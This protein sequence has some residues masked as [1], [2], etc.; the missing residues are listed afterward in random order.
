M[1]TLAA[2]PLA[3][4]SGTLMP[5]IGLGTW[6][7]VGDEARDT[8]RYALSVGYRLID[9]SEQYGNEEPVGRAIRE[10]GVPREEV[11]L[12]TKFNARWHGFELVQ[13]ACDEALKR[14]G[15]DYVDLFLIHWPNPWEDRYVDA[16]RGLLELRAQG[17]ARAVGVSNFKPAHLDRLLAATG[18][19][20][21]V[22]QIELDP[23]LPQVQR[24]E[25]HARHGIVTEAWSPLGRG[26]ALL[27]HPLILQLAERHGKSPAQVVLRWH[28]QVG[29]AFV[30][31]SSSPE[32]I[33]Q[34][35]NILDFDLSDEEM[36]SFAALDE[37]REPMRDS[38]SHG[39]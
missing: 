8:V 18:A 20:P 11:F 34:N 15:T 13:Y 12:T 26:G 23:T 32:R 16:W 35:I 9:T 39:H 31:R 30:A 29:V 3:L 19:V 38:D 27:R 4:A 7:M 33:A 10:S 28:I 25:Y 1:T 37:E 24:R 21:E 36:A 22:N 2:Q 14:L 6:P 5:R 17:K